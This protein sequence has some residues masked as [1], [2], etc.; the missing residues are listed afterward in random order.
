MDLRLY[1]DSVDFDFFQKEKKFGKHTLGHAITKDT[2][3]YNKGGKGKIS[4]ALIGVPNDTNTPNKGTAKAPDE[5]RRHLYELS[6]FDAALKIVDLGNLKK[7]KTDQDTYFALRDIIDYQKENDII[8]IVLGGGQDISVGIARAYHDNKKFS[9]AIADSRVDIKTSREVSN[10][11]NFVSR[12]LRE[13][14]ALFHLQFIGLQSHFVSPATLR[15]LKEQTFDYLQLG[16]IR[17]NYAVLEPVLRNAHFLSF[18]ISAVRHSDAPGHY[19]VSPNGFTGEE[20]CMTAR[21]AGLSNRLST[22]GLFEANPQIDKPGATAALAAQMVWYFLEGVTGRRKE[23]PEID[24]KPFKQYY[25]EMENAGEPLV[26]YHHQPTNR[27]WT[28]LYYNE[29][30]SIVIACRESDYKQA[31]AKEIPDIWWEYIRKTERLL[32]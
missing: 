8:S 24:K 4:V 11:A 17:D 10:A 14:P 26:F 3:S 2:G 23:D 15:F 13:N 16:H 27:W 1:F 6:E 7:G 22:F 28:E 29:G 20:A 18:D 31:A 30:D 9:L 32:K 12:I 25:V 19:S 21:Y 5:I